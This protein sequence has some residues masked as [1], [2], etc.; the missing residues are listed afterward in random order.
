MSILRDISDLIVL[1]RREKLVFHSVEYELVIDPPTYD[2]L[3]T[4][5]TM[6][7]EF[8]F[9]QRDAGQQLRIMDIPVVIDVVPE[10]TGWV[11]RWLGP[12]APAGEGEA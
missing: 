9:F 2:L 12:S 10:G 4:E 7:D 1:E 5:R 11:L 6:A 3:L 8:S